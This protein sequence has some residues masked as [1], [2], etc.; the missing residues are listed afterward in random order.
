MFDYATRNFAFAKQLNILHTLSSEK[1]L[2]WRQYRKYSVV[3]TVSNVPKKTE[4]DIQILIYE[5]FKILPEEGNKNKNKKHQKNPTHINSRDLTETY[6]GTNIR[7]RLYFN[8]CKITQLIG[9]SNSPK[10]LDRGHTQ[11][12][13]VNWYTNAKTLWV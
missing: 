1:H 11:H 7:P 13:S 8:T 6:V 12:P 3:T 2:S 5:S 4:A 9:K 10:W